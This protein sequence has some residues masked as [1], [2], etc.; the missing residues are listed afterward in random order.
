M[1]T[2]ICI[3]FRYPIITKDGG[4]DPINKFVRL[5]KG[6][7]WIAIQHRYTS[8][9]LRSEVVVPYVHNS[10]IVYHVSLVIV[11]SNAYRVKFWLSLCKIVRSSVIL[12]LPLFDLFVF[13]LCTLMLPVFRDCPFLSAL[14]VFS[15]VYLYFLFKIA[16]IISIL[17]FGI[18]CVVFS[19]HTRP[20]VKSF[21]PDWECNLYFDEYGRNF[22]FFFGIRNK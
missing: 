4:R 21:Y 20:G 10:A 22:H 18:I 3:A 1:L 5:S 16:H 12:L 15:N 9:S 8:L 2:H 17:R 7:I 14:S 6:R 19:V 13:V 11:V